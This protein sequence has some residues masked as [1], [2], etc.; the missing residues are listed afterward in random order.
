MGWNW[1]VCSLFAASFIFFGPTVLGFF[2][3]SPFLLHF[4]GFLHQFR[5]GTALGML[6]VLTLFGHVLTSLI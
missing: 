5:D 1:V 2:S 4:P 3:E 6:P